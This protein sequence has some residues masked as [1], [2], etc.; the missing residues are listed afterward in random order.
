MNDQ[1]EEE[2]VS[3]T[4]RNCCDSEEKWHPDIFIPT[5][6]REPSRPEVVWITKKSGN[7]KYSYR[8]L[9]HENGEAIGIIFYQ[10]LPFSK[11]AIVS[12]DYYLV[13]QKEKGPNVYPF[14][15]SKHQ[16]PFY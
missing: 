6:I 15:Y 9:S 4:S 11:L 10:R 3:I 16:L 14:H 5:L 2:K 7:H 8:E 12:P 13:R 1:R